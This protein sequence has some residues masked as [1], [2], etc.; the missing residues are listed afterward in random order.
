MLTLKKYSTYKT[1][2]QAFEMC[3]TKGFNLSYESL[4]GFAARDRLRNLK[5]TD[6][7]FW[8]ELTASAIPEP[9]NTDQTYDEDNED[10]PDAG[11]EDDS[12]LTCDTVTIHVVNSVVPEGALATAEGN[13]ISATEAESMEDVVAVEVPKPNEQDDVPSG[14]P[15]VEE[16]GIGKRKRRANTLY[17]AS[18]FWR[19]HDGDASDEEQ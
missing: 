10:E 8:D 14:L 9:T 1:H 2:L 7:L 18:T 12:D 16:L 11:F 17:K 6:P 3:R 13:L 4:T 5:K 15:A 19:H